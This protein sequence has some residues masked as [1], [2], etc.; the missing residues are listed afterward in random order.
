MC[1]KLKRGLV[2]LA[3]EDIASNSSVFSL[4][5]FQWRHMSVTTSQYPT[6][7]MM[8]KYDDVTL[9]IELEISVPGV[10]NF[11]LYACLYDSLTDRLSDWL[12]DLLT[13][14]RTHL[15]GDLLI[16]SLFRKLLIVSMGLHNVDSFK[17]V[18]TSVHLKKQKN[19]QCNQWIY[20]LLGDVVWPNFY[21]AYMLIKKFAL[22]SKYVDAVYMEFAVTTFSLFGLISSFLLLL[23]VI[24]YNFSQCR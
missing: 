2:T 24:F 8:G 14:I 15:L 13:Y 19:L 23:V 3:T 16:Y 11:C 7:R 9:D 21:V 12:L 5:Q 22:H 4:F 10:S 1:K 17:T 18:P 20:R 6:D